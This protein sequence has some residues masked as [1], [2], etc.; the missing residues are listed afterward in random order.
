MTKPFKEWTVLPHDA[1]G[2]LDGLSESAQEALDVFLLLHERDELHALA[3]ARTLFDVHFERACHELRPRPV[4][5]ALLDVLVV[6]FDVVLFD[7]DGRI[8][9]SHDVRSHF[10]AGREHA[11]VTHGVKPRRGHRCTQAQEEREWIHVDRDC[12]VGERPLLNAMRTR[13]SGPCW[14]RSCAMGGRKM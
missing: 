10:A 7:T 14:T 2:H 3:A 5:R 12:A 1:F 8:G 13:L 9:D 4:A 11:S 6:F